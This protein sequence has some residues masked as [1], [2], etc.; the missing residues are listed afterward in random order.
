MNGGASAAWAL[1]QQAA[2]RYDCSILGGGPSACLRSVAPSGRFPKW[3]P[4]S[5]LWSRRLRRTAPRPTD[6]TIHL[7]A[8]TR[9]CEWLVSRSGTG[10]GPRL[11]RFDLGLSLAHVA[12]TSD[13][14]VME[15]IRAAPDYG[16]ERPPPRARS[17]RWGAS[18]SRSSAFNGLLRG[19]DFR[20]A[21]CS[22]LRIR[23]DVVRGVAAWDSDPCRHE[24]RVGAGALYDRLQLLIV[25]PQHGDLRLDHRIDTR[26]C[27]AAR[28]GHDF[29]RTIG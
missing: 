7:E 3:Q 8:P 16:A 28:R 20:H 1:G 12:G 27:I 22:G 23:A 10:G 11:R 6:P 18:L 25:L 24:Q 14:R 5:T 2:N 13:G 15:L 29:L 26:W 4:A 17:R 21:P 19:F 9:R